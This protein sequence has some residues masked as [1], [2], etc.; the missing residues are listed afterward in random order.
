MRKFLLAV[1]LCCTSLV[2]APVQ[3]EPYTAPTAEA[4]GIAAAPQISA[5]LTSPVAG[6]GT[7]DVVPLTLDIQLPSGWHT[8]WRSPGIA[9]L[10][11]SLTFE[12][13]T[14][15]SELVIDWPRPVRF[16]SQGLDTFGY[17][18][19]VTLPL[20]AKLTTP[21]QALS[22][23]GRVD[24]VICTEICVPAH[25]D[26]SLTVPAGA[27]TPSTNVPLWQSAIDQLPM[28]EDEAEVQLT[29]STR[30]GDA[31]KIGLLHRPSVVV[32][33]VIIET[34]AQHV[35]KAP[36]LAAITDGTE[37]IVP[38]DV[39]TEAAQVDA[40]NITLTFLVTLSGVERAIEITNKVGFE[41]L[42]DA[43]P[44]DTT[45]AP[46]LLLMLALA[47][48]G[49]LILNLMP[50][51]LPV[52]S[53]KLLSV[54]NH[55][56]E[57]KAQIRRGFLATSF[58]I[59]I[60]FWALAALTIGLKQTG[61]ALGWGIQFQQ[62]LFLAFLIAVVTLFTANMWDLFELRAPRLLQNKLA[63]PQAGAPSLG[64][65]FLTGIFATLLA[66]PCTAPFVGT[67]VGFALTSSTFDIVAIFTA[68]GI[69]LAT[70]YLLI[71]LFPAIAHHLPRPGS[72]M[73]WLKIVLG[74]AL[75]ATALWLVWVMWMQT[76]TV[77]AGATIALMLLVLLALY[78]KQL[79]TALLLTLLL[80][81][82]PLSLPSDEAHTATVSTEGKLTWAPFTPDTIA[83]QVAA[84]KVVLVDIT[85]SWCLTCHANKK[86]VLDAEPVASALAA[87]GVMLMRGDWTRPVPAIT[88]Y[89][90]QNGRF[91]IPFNIVYGPT[92]PQGILLPELLTSDVVMNAITQAKGK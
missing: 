51:V 73:R 30:D 81:T 72:W 13:Q 90:Q 70:P 32:N 89:L 75:L 54:I 62:P 76:S 35:F 56:G 86:L 28:T 1:L 14:N 65:E 63:T 4:A 8:Y 85:A 34:A 19:R 43:S 10:P 11:P 57:S 49:G 16:S 67:A 71:A 78:K 38:F 80:I 2:T 87:D 15:V 21:G 42:A 41:A 17:R 84:G 22:L 61:M 66:T 92:A 31:L 48:L 24:V 26:I 3:A 33:D 44:A 53:L 55:A 64:G 69:G 27:A 47:L 18:D 88:S 23:Q 9:G 50:C 5:T 52:L 82:A 83:A 79:V 74:F 45:A 20:H 36:R 6:V 59:V 37:A 25:A 7:Q 29:H 40:Q 68:L 12:T 77:I 58:G 60:S 46:S 91:G 39:P